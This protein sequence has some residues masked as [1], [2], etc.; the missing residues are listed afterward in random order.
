MR[1]VAS[2]LRRLLS[3]PIAA[4]GALVLV[5][6]LVMALFAPQLSPFE[7]T[8]PNLRARLAPPAWAGGPPEHFLGTDHLGRD[9]LSRL[10]Y[11]SR[12]TLLVG[13]AG[14]SLQALLGNP[15]GVVAG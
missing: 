13:L 2:F 9:S 8:A 10:I 14:V 3:S 1:A 15:L 12:I 7:P 5:T 11:G 6:F 4:L